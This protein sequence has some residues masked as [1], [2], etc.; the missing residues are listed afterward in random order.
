MKKKKVLIIV[1]SVL[2][3][4][5]L[6]VG[7]TAGVLWADFSGS[8]R[9]GETITVEIKE[10]SGVSAIAEELES[11]GAI[12][13][14]LLFRVY[15]KLAK[16][17]TKYNY[18]TFTFKNDIGFE[19]I[20]EI[21]INGGEKAQ[22]VTVVIPEGT[23]IN[24]YTKNVDGSKATVRGIATILEEAG[25]CTKADFFAALNE[26]AT[27]GG[28]A[29]DSS[30]EAYYRL[31]GYLFPNTYEFYFHD[32]KECARLAVEKM[33]A[34]TEKRITPEMRAQAEKMGYSINEILT[35]ASIIQMEAGGNSE[36]SIKEMPNVAS[37]FY[38]RLNSASFPTL[39]SSP[40][41]YYGDS[42]ENDDGRYDTY[43]VKGLPVG[44][45]CSPGIDAI[46]AALYPGDKAG[47]FYFV[48]D[49]NG[50]FYYHKTGAEQQA[51]I[52][53]LQQEGN[54]VYEYF[55]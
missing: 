30:D 42:F 50:K 12:D 8:S 45:M 46:N 7:I 18:G 29:A 17:E 28:I 25:V 48:T 38:N 51:T 36:E 4:L 54:W 14:T 47:Y 44:P 33:L 23:G 10:G 40:T 39:G 35:M 22:T 37:I 19:A 49:K 16:T 52:N 1:L 9:S 53:R 26:V 27:D 13:S 21:L 41:C 6:A 20:A 31:E 55:D 3:A 15:S 5:L 11:K 2:L 43:K 24:D 34:E 32:S